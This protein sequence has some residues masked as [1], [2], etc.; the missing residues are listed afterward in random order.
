VNPFQGQLRGRHGQVKEI[1]NVREEPAQRCG[2]GHHLCELLMLLL[3]L[4]LH[5]CH[6]SR[7][8]VRLPAPLRQHQSH[9]CVR[10]AQQQRLLPRQRPQRFRDIARRGAASQHAKQLMQADGM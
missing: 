2:R 8:R 4:L 3:H 7:Q 5:S 9:L 10:A 6:F 1:L